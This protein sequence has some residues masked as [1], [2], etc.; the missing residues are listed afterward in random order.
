MIIKDLTSCPVGIVG[1]H[2]CT[3]HH[4]KK[5]QCTVPNTSLYLVIKETHKNKKIMG[6]I[7]SMII[8]YFWQIFYRYHLWYL[9]WCYLLWYVAAIAMRFYTSVKRS[10]TYTKLVCFVLFL[11]CSFHICRTKF[12]RRCWKSTPATGWNGGDSIL[13]WSFPAKYYIVYD[14]WHGYFIKKI[15]SC[16]MIF[17]IKLHSWCV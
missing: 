15:P 10:Y 7:W 13:E 6:N 8:D 12:G 11:T 9:K 16:T 4:I 1:F 5:S 14:I 2:C 17:L 3:V